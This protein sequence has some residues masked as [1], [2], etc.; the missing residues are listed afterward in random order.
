MSWRGAISWTISG[1]LSV[2]IALAQ[3][4]AEEKFHSGLE[5]HKE[6]ERATSSEEARKLLER[7]IE[8]YVSAVDRDA[9]HYPSLAMWA[10]ATSQLA[11]LEPPGPQR[12]EL[13]ERARRRV[14]EAERSP[15]SDGRAFLHWTRFLLRRELDVGRPLSELAELVSECRTGLQKVSEATLVPEFKS[16]ARTLL[17]ECLVRLGVWETNA[18]TARALINEGLP[19]LQDALGRQPRDAAILFITG[20]GLLRLSQLNED[21]V[22]TLEAIKLLEK[23]VDVTPNDCSMR[24][25]LARALAASGRPTAA[26]ERL[27][28]CLNQ[29]AGLEIWKQLDQIPEFAEMRALPEYHAASQEIRRRM[30]QARAAQVFQDGVRLHREADSLTNDVARAVELLKQAVQRYE[31]AIE[32]ISDR[33][34]PHFLMALALGRLS[35]TSTDPEERDRFMAA[36]RERFE[37]AARCA[38]AELVVHERQGHFLQQIARHPTTPA[39]RRLQL[40]SDARTALHRALEMAR[41]TGER[42]RVARQLASLCVIAAEEDRGADKR[43]LYQEAVAH[44]ESTRKAVATDFTVT[45]LNLWGIALLRLGQMQRDSQMVRRAIERF[46]TALD[47]DNARLDVRYNLACAYAALRQP[48][49]AMRH[50]RICLERD[51]SGLFRSHI[52][53][54]P[55]FDP[56]RD[57]APYRELFGPPELQ[58]LIE[59]RVSGR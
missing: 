57:T 54:D 47:K 37:A 56:I 32:F 10:V 33:A 40:L 58:R 34:Q 45:E 49:A 55:D 27:R 52:L 5:L 39:A 24:L 35:E 11:E 41:F 6:A 13:V 44:F 12:K 29:P 53:E 14:L 4:P 8:H 21:P 48:E 19:L 20:L 42:T 25:V 22:L 31:A 18:P 59:P 3:S 46:Q 15:Q 2:A 43:A 17:G 28:T 26:L 1:M 23:A 7:A 50:A 9:H 30:E 51:E 16:E 36:A 38:D